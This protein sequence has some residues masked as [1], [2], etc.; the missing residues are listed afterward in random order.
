M[1]LQTYFQ[2]SKN[3]EE[4]KNIFDILLE[5]QELYFGDEKSFEKFSNT[6]YWKSLS[7]NRLNVSINGMDTLRERKKLHNIEKQEELFKF[8]DCSTM[9][10]ADKRIYGNY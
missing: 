1:F 9:H 2:I 10:N 7:K 6:D 4:K 3:Q 8:D 5:L